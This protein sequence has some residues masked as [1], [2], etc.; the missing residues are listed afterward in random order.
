MTPK[1]IPSPQF[2]M[3]PW[4]LN[5][6]PSLAVGVP[7]LSGDLLSLLHQQR[8][9]LATALQEGC[10]LG[11]VVGICCRCSS[12]SSRLRVFDPPRLAPYQKTNKTPN[13]GQKDDG[14][15]SICCFHHGLLS[16]LCSLS[17]DAAR[18]GVSWL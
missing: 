2:V 3:K 18:A 6:I 12:N 8:C 13:I 9:T 1:T 5:G 4:R 17:I 16:I 11:L 15:S 7:P 10:I 14:H